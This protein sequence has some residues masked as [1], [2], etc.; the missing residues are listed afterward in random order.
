MVY[1]LKLSFVANG[2]NPTDVGLTSSETIHFGSLE[3]TTDRLGHL[4]LSPEEGDSGAIFVGM[5]HSRSPSLH[6]APK[7]S[8]DQ[9]GS[10][11][12]AGGAP[13]PPAPRVQCG[14]SDHPHH[15]HTDAGEHSITLDHPN[16]YSVNHCTTTR[17]GAPPRPAT[18]LPGGA[19]SVGPCLVDRRRAVGHPSSRRG[20]Q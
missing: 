19:A 1:S 18:G 9:G 4:S 8:S 13:N 2:N 16:D 10:A 12:G 17:Y 7:D 5:V 6:T 3:F 11:L 15:R 20:H 14:N